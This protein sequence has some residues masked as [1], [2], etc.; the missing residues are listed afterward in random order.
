M[1]FAIVLTAA[2]CARIH[3]ACDPL[4]AF[5]AY[6]QQRDAYVEC[7]R[8]KAPEECPR[9]V[10]GPRPE[11]GHDPCDRLVTLCKNQGLW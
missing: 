8:V 4:Y 10:R 11:A 7:V 2:A 9:P 5:E 6:E 3:T 1:L